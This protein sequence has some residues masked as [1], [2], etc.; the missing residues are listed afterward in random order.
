MDAI[1]QRAT[2]AFDP[3]RCGGPRVP[4]LACITPVF[5]NVSHRYGAALGDA[6]AASEAWR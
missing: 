3:S 1:S 2:Q 6:R 5:R 4:W